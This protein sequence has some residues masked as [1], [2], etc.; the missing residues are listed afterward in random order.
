MQ[1]GRKFY[2][3]NCVITPYSSF[4]NYVAQLVVVNS[5][6]WLWWQSTSKVSWM[7]HLLMHEM[8]MVNNNGLF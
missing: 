8:T 2:A 7:N 5:S 4:Q 6:L 1:V 3:K